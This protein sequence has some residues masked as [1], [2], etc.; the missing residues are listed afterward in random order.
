[1][2]ALDRMFGDTVQDLAQV[3][4]RIERIQLRCLCQRIDRGG[5]F[6]TGSPSASP[7]VNHVAPDYT[8]PASDGHGG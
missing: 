7:S 3:I 2:E 6:A 1:M 8:G 5:A 4:L